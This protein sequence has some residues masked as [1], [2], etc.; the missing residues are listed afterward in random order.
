MDWYAV[1]AREGEDNDACL[2]LASAGLRVWRPFELRRAEV[3]RVARR[4]G[5]GMRL[6]RGKAPLAK[7]P[8]SSRHAALRP[9]FLRGVPADR[10]AGG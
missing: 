4:D 2:R 8:A 7:R 9:V 6:R 1:E 5:A 3:Q 10:G